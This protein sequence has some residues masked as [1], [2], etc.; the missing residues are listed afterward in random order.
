MLCQKFLQKRPTFIPFRA[1]VYTCIK[2]LV[3]FASMFP[4]SL[5]LSGKHSYAT[6]EALRDLEQK[7][8]VLPYPPSQTSKNITQRQNIFTLMSVIAQPI[9]SPTRPIL[10]NMMHFY[11]W[12]LVNSVHQIVVWPNSEADICLLKPIFISSRNSAYQCLLPQ[13]DC[14]THSSVAGP[15]VRYTYQ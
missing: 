11:L 10:E 13:S 1:T 8:L 2:F 7:V 9:F 12:A 3:I 4:F 6:L 5:Q 14:S 15:V